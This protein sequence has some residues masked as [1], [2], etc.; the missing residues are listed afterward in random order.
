MI[1]L[2]IDR[3]RIGYGALLDNAGCMCPVGFLCAAL[4]VK[5]AEMLGR[6]YAAEDWLGVPVG[7]R[8]RGGSYGN[9]AERVISIHEAPE[10]GGNIKTSRAIKERLM[11]NEFARSGVAV[12]FT[13]AYR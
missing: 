7:F 10:S 3:A 12:E 11:T 2:T 1:A 4:G 6:G 8:G 9:A 5:P 13:G